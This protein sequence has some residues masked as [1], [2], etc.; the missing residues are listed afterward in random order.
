MDIACIHPERVSNPL[1]GPTIH[2]VVGGGPSPDGVLPS[3]VCT[4][5]SRSVDL[6]VEPQQASEPQSSNAELGQVPITK[7]AEIR[8]TTCRVHVDLC[9]RV[10]EQIP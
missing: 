2:S 4:A 3:L 6:H 1:V 10:W 7:S 9:C 5:L 8:E